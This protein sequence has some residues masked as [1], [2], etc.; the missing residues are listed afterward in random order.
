M[1]EQVD[2]NFLGNITIAAKWWRENLSLSPQQCNLFEASLIKSCAKK[3]T[4]HWFVNNPTKGQAFRSISYDK[5]NRPDPLLREVADDISVDIF[6][7]FPKYMENCIMWIDP[8]SVIVKTSW[9]YSS[10]NTE[11]ILFPK[12]KQPAFSLPYSVPVQ[13][14]SPVKNQSK[15]NAVTKVQPAEGTIHKSNLNKAEALLWKQFCGQQMDSD[16]N[17]EPNRIFA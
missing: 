16:K 14:S 9:S 8:N 4:S 15:A 12:S 17:V 2:P 6:S 7:C 13:S 10:K 1:Q 3:F 11:E 5:F